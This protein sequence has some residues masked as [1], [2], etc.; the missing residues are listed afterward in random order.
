[1]IERYILGS[2]QIFIGINPIIIVADS[3]G[4]GGAVSNTVTN[5]SNFIRICSSAIGFLEI[6]NE[7]YVFCCGQ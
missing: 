7:A 6:I 4:I 2:Q 3:V 1:M 5:F